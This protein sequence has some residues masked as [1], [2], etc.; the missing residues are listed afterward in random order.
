VPERE[1]PAVLDLVARWPAQVSSEVAVVEVLRSARRVSADPAVQRRA[2]EVLARV[3][4]H[5]IDEDLLLRAALLGPPLLRSL[6]ALHLA[7][8]LAMGDDV[9]ALVAYDS[10]LATAAA[11]AGLRVLAPA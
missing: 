1:T 8:A 6:D 10:R 3:L 5:R 2:A 7:T 4:L 11:D 9:G